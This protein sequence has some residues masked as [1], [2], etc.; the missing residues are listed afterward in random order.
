MES[1]TLAPMPSFSPSLLPKQSPQETHTGDSVRKCQN[2][3]DTPLL[4]IISQHNGVITNPRLQFWYGL[5]K[6]EAFF[7]RKKIESA[8]K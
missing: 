7:E 1:R 3:T 5:S 4:T 8:R 2:P 6:G